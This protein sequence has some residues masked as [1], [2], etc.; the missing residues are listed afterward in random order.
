MVIFHSSVSLPEGIGRYSRWPMNPT[1]RRLTYA[2]CLG[3]SLK[4]RQKLSVVDGHCCFTN[5]KREDLSRFLCLGLFLG[6]DDRV[7]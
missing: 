5:P 4:G 6:I 7:R 3:W 2:D 1:N